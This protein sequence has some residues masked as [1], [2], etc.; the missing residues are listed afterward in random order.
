MKNIYVIWPV[1]DCLQAASFKQKTDPIDEIK[2][3]GKEQSAGKEQIISVLNQLNNRNNISTVNIFVPH[4]ESP[5]Q[6]RER[7]QQ[8]KPETKIQWF[9]YKDP[10]NVKEACMGL[11]NIELNPD[12][13]G[14]EEL[15][16]GI[17]GKSKMTDIYLRYKITRSFLGDK[18]GNQALEHIKEAIIHIS[19]D[20][21]HIPKN[22]EVPVMNF[23]KMN[24]PAIEGET[25]TIRELKKDIHKLADTDICVLLEGETGTGKEA[26]AFFLHDL[27]SRRKKPYGAINCAGLREDR[28][29]SDLFGH[30]KGAFTGAEKDRAGII[31]TL[32]GGT[33]F[34]DEFPNMPITVQAMLLRFLDSGSFYPLGAEE[35]EPKNA[36]VRIVAG[37]Q[38]Q[39]LMEKRKKDRFR[40]D[41]YYRIAE[42]KITVPSLMDIRDD[43]MK[44]IMHLVYKIENDPERRFEVIRYFE[45]H[46]SILKQYRWPGNVR[47]L[48]T[49]VKRRVKIG[50][51]ED[52]IKEISSLLQKDAASKPELY[53]D[54]T[55]TSSELNL[56]RFND[57][58]DDESIDTL[59][60]VKAGYVRHVYNQLRSKRQSDTIIAKR[61]GFGSVNTL[62]KYLKNNTPTR[63]VKKS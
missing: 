32:N 54:E 10:Q 6:V 48:A 38:P 62:K 11:P 37:A 52:V 1:P 20:Q 25:E 41:L 34:L 19:K 28:L 21:N 47:Q 9:T 12:G 40:K 26:A 8:F 2:I 46:Q 14:I 57:V 30:V 49:Y 24:F 39:L 42:K 22:E 59:D 56:V 3:A 45:Q 29:C 44:I 61:L 15:K 7:L 33:L 18:E 13:R 23:Q 35:G 58:Y 51:D 63:P 36:D 50:E 53:E 55:Q 16:E 60:E 4:I 5:R 27:S 43:I 17:I 31:K